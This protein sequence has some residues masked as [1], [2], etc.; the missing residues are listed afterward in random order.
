MILNQVFERK[1]KDIQN[2]VGLNQNSHSNFR[3]KI[4]YF[5]KYIENFNYKSDTFDQIDFNKFSNNPRVIKSIHECH[6]LEMHFSFVQVL[7]V[8]QQNNVR[9]NNNV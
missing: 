6:R 5:Y 4:D 3:A 9:S 7:S 1:N 2:Y 8:T